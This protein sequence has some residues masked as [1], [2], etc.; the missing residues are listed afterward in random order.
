MCDS[1]VFVAVVISFTHPIALGY[2]IL[3]VFR[4]IW[5]EGI[6]PSVHGDERVVHIFCNFGMFFDV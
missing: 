4:V 6:R 1:V 5:L 2:E 3:K